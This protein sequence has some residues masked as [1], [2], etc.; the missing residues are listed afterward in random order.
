MTPQEFFSTYAQQAMEQQ[1]RYGIPASVTLAQCYLESGC[2]KG[3]AFTEANN[4]FCVKSGNSSYWNEQGHYILISDDKKD[5]RF[6][7]YDSL[8]ASFE[9][10]SKVLMHPR[11]AHCQQLAS[12]DSKGW[13]KGLVSGK[14][15]YASDSYYTQ[16]LDNI[17]KQYDLA[18]Y[19]QQA[20]VLAQQQGHTPGY[21]RGQESPVAARHDDGVFFR[22]P[23]DGSELTMTS[24]F[25]MRVHPVKKIQAMHNGID[26]A[27]KSGTQLFSTEDHGVVKRVNWGVDR[28]GDGK[29]D[30]DKNGNPVLNGKCVEVEYKHGN[31]TYTVQYLHMSRVDVK[32]GQEV[33]HDTLL[34]LSGATGRGTGAHL[35][36]GVMKNGQYINPLEYLAQM[37]VLTGDDVTIKDARKGGDVLAAYRQKVDQNEMNNLLAQHTSANASAASPAKAA[38]VA[39]QPQSA[40][41]KKG[42]DFLGPE[43]LLM[44]LM[45]NGGEGL[46]SSIF[47]SCITL[48]M[49]ADSQ[50]MKNATPAEKEVAKKMVEGK[51]EDTYVKDSDREVPLDGEDM[52]SRSSL[53]FEVDSPQQGT[54]RLMEPMPGQNQVSRS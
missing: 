13:T 44:G 17:I 24:P 36:Y 40:G 28:D 29:P 53:H 47:M 49:A 3:R 11:Y 10:H 46:L 21:L 51:E 20:K 14:E 45:G 34:G 16:K 18:K 1:V 48:C 12:D 50:R 43:S 52:A 35:H 26:I 15:K 5:E 4:A 9:D 30:L 8:E 38:D 42:L 39:L 2:G 25:G 31:D 7:K 41:K 27:V 37:S 23:V 32:E 54:G 6:R 22:M 19:D 33:S